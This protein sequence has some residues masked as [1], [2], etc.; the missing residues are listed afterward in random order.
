MSPPRLPN[1]A[2][3]LLIHCRYE[4]SVHGKQGYIVLALAVLL[5]VIDLCNIAR[6]LT[7]FI[8]SGEKF[9][10]KAFWSTVILGRDVTA[11]TGEYT[12]LVT[13]EPE[14]TEEA[15]LVHNPAHK[16]VHYDSRDDYDEVDLHQD[17]AQWASNVHHHR[18]DYSQ[19][20]VSDGTVFEPK[21]A[22]SDGTLHDFD[23]HRDPP[24]KQPVLRRIGSI[25]FATSER[26]LLLSGL[27]EFL[28]GFV[29]YTGQS[30]C[31]FLF[32]ILLT[33]FTGG[34]RENYVNGCL[35]HLISS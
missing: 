21:S 1:G 32:F 5:T 12:G 15:K 19:S 6:R 26:A 23:Y 10:I 17:T 11:M 24:T 7:A 9:V 28:S 18:R 2:H 4:G 20:A 31:S 16:R 25:A 22:S 8:R 29:V 35:A 30:D 27:A 3:R 14:E 13:D 33:S 34:C